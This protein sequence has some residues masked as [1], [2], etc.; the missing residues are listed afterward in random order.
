MMHTFMF[1]F[2]GMEGR[3][4]Q[5]KNNDGDDNKRVPLMYV[6]GRQRRVKDGGRDGCESIL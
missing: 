6:E 5:K 2:F 3:A 1:C 4:S